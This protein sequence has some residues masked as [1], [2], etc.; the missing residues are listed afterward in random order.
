MPNGIRFRTLLSMPKKIPEKLKSAIPAR[1]F[2][3][4]SLFGENH[5]N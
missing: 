1:E 5:Q 2:Y 4:G 3:G